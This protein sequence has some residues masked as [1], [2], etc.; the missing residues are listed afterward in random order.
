MVP[1]GGVVAAGP[2]DVL[3]HTGVDFWSWFFCM[4][5]VW[6]AAFQ[7]ARDFFGTFGYQT[8]SQSACL[9]WGSMWS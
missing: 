2:A 1:T 7:I 5:V 3:G 9:G 6:M 4:S 8:S